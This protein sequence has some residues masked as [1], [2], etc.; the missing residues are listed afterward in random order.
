MQ[1]WVIKDADVMCSITMDNPRIRTEIS[2]NEAVLSPVQVPL[3]GVLKPSYMIIRDE[4]QDSILLVIR[5]T[6]SLK[7]HACSHA[8]CVEAV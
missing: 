7:V 2:E 3:A 6:H 8:R 5:G 4:Q 1:L